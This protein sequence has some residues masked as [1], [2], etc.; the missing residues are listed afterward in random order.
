MLFRYL[1]ICYHTGVMLCS[2]TV[3]N[4]QNSKT[5]ELFQNMENKFNSTVTVLRDFFD[6]SSQV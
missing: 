2:P 6:E 5:K 4:E 3:Y 1:D